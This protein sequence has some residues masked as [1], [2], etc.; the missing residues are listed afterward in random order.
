MQ[1]QGFILFQFGK[2]D[3][4]RDRIIRQILENAVRINRISYISFIQDILHSI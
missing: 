1:Q 3:A 4:K 2:K